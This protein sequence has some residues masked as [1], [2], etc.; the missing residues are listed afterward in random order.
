MTSEKRNFDNAASTW[1]ENPGRVKINRDIGD[2][3]L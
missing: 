1:D 3:I 2:A